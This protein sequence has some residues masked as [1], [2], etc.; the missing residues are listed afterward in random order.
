[1]IAIKMK[2]SV[3]PKL[4]QRLKVQGYC[5]ISDNR[6]SELAFGNRFAYILCSGLIFIGVTMVSIPILCIMMIIALYGVLLPYHP[7]DYIYNHLLG[8]FLGKPKLPPRSIQIKFACSIATIWLALTTG[9]FFLDYVMT[10]YVFGGVLFLL[11]FTV[12]TTDICLP[13][14][15]YNYIFKVKI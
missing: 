10:G 9:L 8:P 14:L 3:S 12:S 11:T 4:V 5:G 1:M 7:F 6:I 13:S 2:N 15:L